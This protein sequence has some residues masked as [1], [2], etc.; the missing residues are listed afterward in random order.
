MGDQTP[1]WFECPYI[2]GSLT[3]NASSATKLAT[4]R[5][6]NGTSFNGTANITTANWGTARTITIGSSGKSVNG[7]GNVSFSRD[8][9]NVAYGDEK[10]YSGTTVVNSWYRIATSSSGITVVE[11]L[12]LQLLLVV[13]IQMLYYRLELLMVILMEQVLS[14]SLVLTMVVYRLRQ[15]E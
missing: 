2:Y 8:E 6:I 15:L 14:N 7:S 9:M 13:I 3:G 1:I 4:A 11:Y 12:L 10:S 5:T